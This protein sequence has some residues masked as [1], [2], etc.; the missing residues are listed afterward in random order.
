MKGRSKSLG[1]MEREI[2]IMILVEDHSLRDHLN[3]ILSNL[4]KGLSVC[5]EASDVIGGLR[6]LSR[7]LPDLLILDVDMQGGI[8]FQ[9]LDSL[10]G[11]HTPVIM[12]SEEGENAI[13]AFRYNTIDFIMKPV[14]IGLFL[15]AID[16]AREKIIPDFGRGQARSEAPLKLAIHSQNETEYIEIRSIVRMEASGCYTHL[17]LENGR[18]ITVTKALGEYEAL[19]Q[20]DDF[21]RVHNSHVI[22]MHHIKKFVRKD[23]LMVRM[24]DDCL[25]PIA[26]RRKEIFEQRIRAVAI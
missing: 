20:E 6:Q 25:V 10:P 9:M 2:R 7:S 15:A 3:Q 22:N 12:L 24:T 13:R 17:Y 8:G 19:L 11:M 26:V 23:G 16:R 5:G 4:H 21:T 18:K 1:T 14:D